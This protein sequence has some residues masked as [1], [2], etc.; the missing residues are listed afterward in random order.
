MAGTRNYLTHHMSD[1]GECIDR[2]MVSWL[3]G[4][5][6]A[7]IRYYRCAVRLSPAS[8]LGHYLLGYTLNE[9]GRPAE[10]RAEFDLVLKTVDPSQQA[11]WARQATIHTIE[12]DGELKQ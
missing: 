9:I 1:A 4:D 3:V 7:A 5:M 12:S 8:A 6:P 11:I 10:A 2:G